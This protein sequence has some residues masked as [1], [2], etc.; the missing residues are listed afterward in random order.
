MQTHERLDFTRESDEKQ[1]SGLEFSD[2]HRKL[3]KSEKRT[4]VRVEYDGRHI[5][6]DLTTYIELQVSQNNGTF[7]D[8]KILNF[9][10][11]CYIHNL[12]DSFVLPVTRHKIEEI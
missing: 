3:F 5:V 6:I 7:F 8:S 2:S 10:Y 1:R 11:F 4:R 9:S 12:R